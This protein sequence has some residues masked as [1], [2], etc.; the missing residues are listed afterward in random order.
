MRRRGLWAALLLAVLAA[1]PPL[2]V[3]LPQ[4][5][6]YPAHLAA[7]HVLIE[8]GHNASIDAAYRIDWR[9]IPNLGTELLVRPLAALV[10]LEPAGRL[11]VIA[12]P[13]LTALAFVSVDRV[14]RGRT[15]A[16]GLLA[17]ATVW[18]PALLMGFLN[19]ALAVALAFLALALW[20]RLEHWRWR[21]VLFLAISPVVWLC[22][23]SGWGVM[24][25]L[26]GGYEWQKRGLVRGALATWPLWP[27]LALTLLGGSGTRGLGGYGPSMVTAKYLNWVTGLRDQNQLLDRLS[28]LLLGGLPLLAW[29]RGRADGRIGRAAILFALL[30]LAVP[31]ELGGGDFADYRLVA[32]ALACGCLAI[33]VDL[34]RRWLALALLPFLVRLAVTTQAWVADAREAEE[35]LGAL[36]HIP[37]GSVVA[38]AYPYYLNWRQPPYAHIFSYA[39]VRR[40]ALTNSD[41]ADP[42][43]HMLQHRD[44]DPAFIDPS[45]RI[46]VAHGARPDLAA[47]VPARRAQFLWYVGEE[48]PARLPDGATVVFASRHSQLL[49]LAKPPVSR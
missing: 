48:P 47:L 4:M 25:V 44:G 35:A 22:H 9:W 42:G 41:F 37:Q 8:S 18:A 7:W 5:A 13:A 34:P 45:A 14:L 40:H 17:L 43:V 30:S 2:L 6:D 20:I 28:V 11:I 3:S 19:F 1:L 21:P 29:A 12:I 36:D 39:T 31:R 38:G 33:D 32:V 26:I 23:L 24:A 16:G 49:R 10:G 15:S 27:T 46:G